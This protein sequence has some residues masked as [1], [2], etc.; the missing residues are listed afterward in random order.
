MPQVEFQYETPEGIILHVTADITPGRR[1]FAPSLDGPGEP[2]E[3]PTIEIVEVVVKDFSFAAEELEG[4]A[5]SQYEGG[6]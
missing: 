5:W 3:E 1:G 6:I 4:T 2:D